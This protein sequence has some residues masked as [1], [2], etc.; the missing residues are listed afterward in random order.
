[1][2]QNI[3]D[4]SGVYPVFRVGG[5]TQNRATFNASQEQGIILK[6]KKPT[7]DQPSALTIGPRWMESFQQFPKGTR[8]IY[9]LSFYNA[10][11]RLIGGRD[12]INETVTEAKLAYDGIKDD[13]Y[14]FEIGNEVDGESRLFITHG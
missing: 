14:A 10:H 2:V 13:L 11:D 9:G 1:M 7:D 3:K 8:Y 6:F 5:S 12:G 4:I